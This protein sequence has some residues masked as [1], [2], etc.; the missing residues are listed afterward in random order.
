MTLLCEKISADSIEQVAEALAVNR[1]VTK[2]FLGGRELQQDA[3]RALGEVLR[4]TS[5]LRQLTWVLCCGHD[6]CKY[7]YC[8]PNRQYIERSSIRE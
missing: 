3:A 2:L 5:A 4:V 7:N 6:K 8:F 1:T